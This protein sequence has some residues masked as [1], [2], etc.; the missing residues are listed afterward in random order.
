MISLPLLDCHAHIAPDAT[1]DQ[2]ARLAPSVVFAVTRSP[3]EA[4]RVVGRSDQRVVWGLGAHPALV[5][6][7]GGL[8]PGEL[9][10]LLPR[11]AFVGEIGLDR[12]SGRMDRQ[13][14]FLRCVLEALGGHPAMVSIHSNGAVNEV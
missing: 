2:L 3:E 10:E 7:G 5:A 12:R 13:V 4:R 1:A 6:K 8:D 9:I 14:E 11:F